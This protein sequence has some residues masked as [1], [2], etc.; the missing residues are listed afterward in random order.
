ML[1][2]DKSVCSNERQRQTEHAVYHSKEK[3]IRT[4]EEGDK[5]E[6][7]EKSECDL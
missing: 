4:R 6:G 1:K 2:V 5:S 3:T 7:S